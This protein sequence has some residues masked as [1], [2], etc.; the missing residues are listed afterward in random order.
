MQGPP[1]PKSRSGGSG[2]TCLGWCHRSAKQHRTAAQEMAETAAGLLVICL[3]RMVLTSKIIIIIN[4]RTILLP[5]VLGTQLTELHRTGGPLHHWSP[6]VLAEDAELQQPPAAAL[7]N[8]P[9]CAKLSHLCQVPSP[10]PQQQTCPPPAQPVAPAGAAGELR[11]S[12]WGTAAVFI[13]DYCVSW[14]TV[15]WGR[16]QENRTGARS[17]AKPLAEPGCFPAARAPRGRGA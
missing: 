5:S 7:S 9:G 1:L 3:S 8:V 12:G 10:D 17:A 16:G 6:R 14:P 2:C 4:K 13:F 11:A 15:R